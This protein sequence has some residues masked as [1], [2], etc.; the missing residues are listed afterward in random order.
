[1]NT[2]LRTYFYS[3]CTTIRF[4]LYLIIIGF[5]STSANAQVS[6]LARVEYTYI[7]QADS[8]NRV[9]RFRAFVNYPI[10]LGW[11]GSF[12]VV[13]LEYRKLDLDFEDPVPF[14]LDAL[15]KFQMFR[16]SVAFTCKMKNDWRLAANVGIE[17]N[18]NFELNSVINDD[19]NLSGALFFIKDKSGD[20]IEKP[21]RFIIG[22]NYSTNA[23]RPFPI[24]LIN[25]YK[26]FRP[27]WSY[28]LG[29][30]KTNIKHFLGKK[31][32]VQAYITLDGFFSNIQN[33]LDVRYNDGTSATA[34]NISMTLVLGGIG[35]EYNF[36]KNLVAYAYG[37][38]TFFNE[39]RLRDGS[40]NNLFKINEKNTF[41]LRS[42]IKFKI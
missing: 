7:P 34:E 14:D 8:D 15:G 38:H 6:D 9:S 23:G 18:S 3:E 20:G 11:E 24:P 25:Y 29:T 32:S 37:G 16:S 41:Y 28:S 19:L 26:K 27:N 40:R 2:S 5:F 30:P 33:N 39:I 42:G 10:R 17:V 36:T 1:M 13:G 31:Q 4:F 22:L 21:S 35:Y 12:V